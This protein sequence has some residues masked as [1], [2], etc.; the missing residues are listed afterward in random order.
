MS[1]LPEHYDLLARLLLQ[2]LLNSLWQGTAIVILVGLLLRFIGHVSATTRHAI[3][4]VSLLAIGLL[5]FL[6]ATAPQAPPLA[7]SPASSSRREAAPPEPVLRTAIATENQQ[8]AS[9]SSKQQIEKAK[10]AGRTVSPPQLPADTWDQV[11]SGLTV[12]PTPATVSPSI[13][14]FTAFAQVEQKSWLLRWSER[15][16]SGKVPLLLISL[17][18]AVCALML[19][20]LLRSYLSLL[21]LRRALYPLPSEQD[22]RI[23]RLVEGFGL[24]RQIRAGLSSEVAMPMT[25]G[26]IKPLIILP[27]GIMTDLSE[28]EFDSI[29]AHELAHIKRWDYLTNL[30]QRLI[31]VYLFFHPAVWVI[32][33]RL[34][35]ERELAC[36]D[37]AVQMT[38]EARRYAS[39]LT[40]LVE[41]LSESKPLAV[42]EGMLFGKHVISRRIEMILNPSRNT[43][44]FISKPAVL[45]AIGLE[46]LLLVVSLFLAPVIAVPLLQ[47]SNTGAKAQNSGASAKEQEAEKGVLADILSTNAARSVAPETLGSAGAELLDD[48]LPDRPWLLLPDELAVVAASTPEVELLSSPDASLAPKAVPFLSMQEAQI[49]LPAPLPPPASPAPVGGAL[50]GY[51][52]GVLRWGP[53][54]RRGLLVGGTLAGYPALEKGDNQAIPESELLAVLTEIAKRDADPKVRSEALQGI[55]RL[56]SEASV[57]A[58]LKLYDEVSDAQMKKEIL[59]Y[60][61]RRQGDNSLAIAKLVSVAKTEKD[62]ELRKQALRQLLGVKGD[63]GA[64]SLIEIYDSL[65]DAKMKQTVIRYLAYNKS[66]K[67]IDKLIQIAK[68]DPDPAIRQMAIRSL[69][70]IDGHLFIEML[71]RPPSGISLNVRPDIYFDFSFDRGQLEKLQREAQELSEKAFE[72]LQREAQELSEKAR[73]QAEKAR[74]KAR[75][76]AEKA[77]EKAHEQAERAREQAREILEKFQREYLD[78]E[79]SEQLEHQ[80]EDVKEAVGKAREF[81]ER[82]L[83]TSPLRPNRVQPNTKNVK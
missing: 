2:S 62:E 79:L 26:W 15:W 33:H 64:N 67:A 6:P 52:A 25:I 65:Q 53:L 44:T 21:R 72:K 81:W 47:S 57:N 14:A 28:S 59:G 78:C 42:A 55:Y 63:E 37:W 70:G 5:P 34:V 82:E 12:R 66:R 36:D 16:L 45:S 22:Q 74:E 49:P 54:E 20:R 18:F 17:W 3:W 23:K 68:T 50:A 80:S 69:S 32:G 24:K 75:E 13:T 61:I 19:W 8:S 43:T 38:G 7:A 48:L 35:V 41:A 40:R 56:R 51:P 46:A 60:L 27:Q 9:Y 73:E 76:Q 11:M 29:A 31:Q 77:R 58:L 39:C 30:L 1:W 71:D 10:N 83:R 4:L